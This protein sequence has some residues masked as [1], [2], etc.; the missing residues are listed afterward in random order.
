M[1]VFL[2]LLLCKAALLI[3]FYLLLTVSKENVLIFI[4][5]EKK[6]IRRGCGSH[7][8]PRLSAFSNL[9]F[10]LFVCFLPVPLLLIAVPSARIYPSVFFS[11]AVIVGIVAKPA[12]FVFVL[13][14]VSLV[15]KRTDLV[16][17]LFFFFLSFLE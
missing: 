12:S 13:L 3:F 11:V 1:W 16:V 9:S 15:T 4:K 8:I 6:K 17:P 7:H 5:L 10:Y 2:C 14:S